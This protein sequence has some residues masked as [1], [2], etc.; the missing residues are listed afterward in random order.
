MQTELPLAWKKIKNIESVQVFRIPDEDEKLIEQVKQVEIDLLNKLQTVCDANGI[1]VFLIYGSLLGAVRHGSIIPG[2]DDI[3]VALMREDYDK[4]MSLQGEFSGKYFLQTPENDMFFKGGYAKLRNTQTTA[5]TPENWYVDCCEGISIDIF[6]IDNCSTSK[7]KEKI[8]QIKIKFYQRMLFAYSYGFF[9]AYLDMKMLIWKG[10]KYLGKLTKRK[11][12][13]SKLNKEF[14]CGDKKSDS[15]CIYCH[16]TPKGKKQNFKRKWFE[17]FEKIP[18]ENLQV[19]IPSDYEKILYCRY[20]NFLSFSV[21]SEDSKLRHGFYSLKDSYDY[22]KPKF[23]NCCRPVPK[24]KKI[25]FAGDRILLDEFFERFGAKYMPDYF[26]E[27]EK[28]NLKIPEIYTNTTIL[29][30][31]EYLKIK[32]N[33]HYFI[34]S[35][36]HLHESELLIKKAGITD[37]FIFVKNRLWLLFANSQ[38]M[39]QEKLL[40]SGT[41]SALDGILDKL[42]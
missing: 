28:F 32:S 15:V 39:I 4:L 19:L 41:D 35:S 13:I 1:K 23:R 14:T 36:I 26:V 27:L 42:N 34:L 22:Y 10:Y 29:S 40:R 3:D 6:P 5:I 24:G 17:K 37:Y 11:K 16:Y 7:V 2:D 12:I 20:K 31:E 38:S 9:T 30:L 8:R 25:V 33:D 18:F 21:N